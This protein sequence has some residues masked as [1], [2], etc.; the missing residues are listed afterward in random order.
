MCRPVSYTHL[1]VN[2]DLD[3]AVR[4]FAGIVAAEKARTERNQNFIDEVFFQ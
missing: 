1:V 4:D 3:G 2:D